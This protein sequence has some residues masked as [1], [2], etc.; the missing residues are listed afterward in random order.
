MR[1]R[2]PNVLDRL[3]VFWGAMDLLG[4]AHYFTASLWNGRIPFWT[5]I[6]SAVALGEQMGSST[7]VATAILGSCAYVVLAIVGVLLMRRNRG[8]AWTSLA[9][10]LVRPVTIPTLFLAGPALA[11]AGLSTEFAMAFS[12]LAEILRAVT[13]FVWLRQTRH[14]PQPL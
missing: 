7:P 10:T 9:M 4:F 12:L 5:D 6:N 1:N 2:G 13:V 11:L 8:A 3:V 14:S